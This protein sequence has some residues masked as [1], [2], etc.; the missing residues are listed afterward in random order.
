MH[1]ITDTH[2][3]LLHG[4]QVSLSPYL[5]DAF[6]EKVLIDVWKAMFW[7]SDATGRTA[8]DLVFWWE[9]ARKYTL[10]YF[11]SYF[12]S[13]DR[14]TLV[15][16][17]L[18][19]VITLAGLVWFC[20]LHPH[21]GYIGVWAKRHQ[22]Q[23]YTAAMLHLACRWAFAEFDW[24]VILGESPHR[25]VQQLHLRPSLRAAGW[26]HTGTIPQIVP[27][28][29]GSGDVQIYALTRNAWEVSNAT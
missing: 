8:L 10:E 11:L 16:V 5:H 18:D 28:K 24:Q 29:Q 6:A 14:I 15:G 27:S 2:L 23:S 20:R 3:P 22:P 25:T 9:D 7:D 21:Y 19:P 1:E 17:A 13:E 4:P 12:A 26:R